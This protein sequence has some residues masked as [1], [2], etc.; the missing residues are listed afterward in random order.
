MTQHALFCV[1][2]SGTHI[3]FGDSYDI[4]FLLKPGI[5]YNFLITRQMVQTEKS[6][7]MTQKS[8]VDSY[9]NAY[10]RIRT[11]V[12][13]GYIRIL[14]NSIPIAQVWCANCVSISRKHCDFISC[15]SLVIHCICFR[16]AQSVIPV[17]T[18]ERQMMYLLAGI[19]ISIPLKSMV[20]VAVIAR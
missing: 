9:Q 4:P 2:L 18:T 20:S 11:P 6:S 16:R 15:L 3:L 13:K 12:K 19:M 8:D 14:M 7:R 1:Q 5:P 17:V 10:H